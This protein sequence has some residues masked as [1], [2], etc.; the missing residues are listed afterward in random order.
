MA[1]TSNTYTGNGSNKLFSITFS[2]IK[3][4]DIDVYL[5]GTLQTVTTQYTFANATTVEFVAAPANG[6]VVLLDRSTDDSTLAATFFPGSSIKA[7]DLNADFDQTLYVVQEINNKAIKTTDP[8]YANKTYIDSR[9]A[10]KVNKSGDTMSG[11][12]AMGGNKVT[13]LGTTSNAADAATKQYVDDNALLYSGSPAFTQ[14]GA[15]AVTRSWSNKLK[16]VVSVK[17]FGAV[18]NGVTEDTDAIQAAINYMYSLGGGTVKFPA[19]TYKVTATKGTTIIGAYDDGTHATGNIAAETPSYQAYSLKLKN[20]VSL[21]GEGG[22]SIVGAYSYGGASLSLPICINL[23]DGYLNVAIDNITFLYHFIAI[24]G[25]S[26]VTQI[27]SRFT[28]LTLA[29]CAFGFHARGLER[30]YFDNVYGQGTGS[31]ISVGGYWCSRTDTYQEGGG[32]ADKNYFGYIWNVY[33]RV[34]GANEAAIDTYFNTY[35]FKT[36]NNSTRLVPAGGQATLFPYKGVCGTALLVMAR[37]SRSSN[38]NTVANLSHG[39]APRAAVDFEY[40]FGNSGGSIYLEGNGYQ[41]NASKT[42]QI[43]V[44]F[45]DPYLGAGV[46]IQAFIG[47]VPN[48]RVE[49]QFVAGQRISYDLEYPPNCIGC[50]LVESHTTY[51]IPAITSSGSISSSG[52]ISNSGSTKITSGQLGL[53]SNTAPII[54]VGFNATTAASTGIPVNAGGGGRAMLVI[55]SRNITA[56]TNTQVAMYLLNCPFDGGTAPVATLISG[57][58]FCTFGVDGSGNITVIGSAPYGNNIAVFVGVKY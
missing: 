3:T 41:D 48:A 24:G 4:T 29:G 9:D 56:G 23:D 54:Q 35:F 58:N 7:A 47:G 34:M 39:F 26:A 6:A 27:T 45:T 30:C 15:G 1:T 22:V 53:Y 11:N 36:A 55:A 17:D 14:D 43:G 33:N 32:F 46:K 57:T 19:G 50:T 18:G 13:G 2:Y 49:A 25:I 20:G 44:G 31:L 38:S 5:N 51:R 40:S 16:D 12:L 52:D 42:N 28:N 10:L 8:L 21:V 37:Y